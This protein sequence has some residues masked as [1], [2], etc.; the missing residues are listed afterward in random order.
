[1]NDVHQNMDESYCQELM[2]VAAFGHITTEESAAFDGYLAGNEAAR[3]EYSELLEVVSLLPLAL[4]EAEPSA[5]LRDR[6][7]LAINAGH[8]ES[9][10]ESSESTPPDSD[11]FNAGMPNNISWIASRTGKMMAAAAA[12]I[13]V[14]IT[15]LTIGMN[16]NGTESENID[17]SLIPDGVS[18]SLEYQPDDQKFVF[19][20]HDMPAAPRDMV[21]QVWLID[22]N[23]IPESVGVMEGSE[24][25]VESDK[26]M[27]SAFAITVEPGP[28][29]SDAP[30][31]DPIVVAPI[32]N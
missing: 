26:S 19:K 16:I 5:A 24:F 1:M 2:G 12:V 23:D 32:Q 28:S 31:S 22:T 6:L 20:S 11:R 7:E 27:V 29:G 17:L 15:A 3:R 30:T 10:S 18:G 4:V 13:L 21:Y 25:E 9:N 14:A 8:A